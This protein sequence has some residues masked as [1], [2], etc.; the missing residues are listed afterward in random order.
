MGNP[1]VSGSHTRDTQVEQERAFCRGYAYGVE[2]T[3]EAHDALLGVIVEALAAREDAAAL[4]LDGRV[5]GSLARVRALR[6]GEGETAALN[7]FRLERC[8]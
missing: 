4:A 7:L 1:A 3:I 5:N 6:L 2:Q 8:S